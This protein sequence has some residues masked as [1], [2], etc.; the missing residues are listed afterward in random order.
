MVTIARAL[1]RIAPVTTSGRSDSFMTAGLFCA[2][3]L[4]VALLLAAYSVDLG[5]GF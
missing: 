3:G 1:L 2:A 5:V 4:S